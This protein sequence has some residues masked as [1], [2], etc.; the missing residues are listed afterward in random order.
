MW[1]VSTMSTYVQAVR[2]QVA[3][4]VFGTYGGKTAAI[5]TEAAAAPTSIAWILLEKDT[6]KFNLI[7]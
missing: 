5:A 1:I 6:L 4:V 3:E 2:R 7:Q